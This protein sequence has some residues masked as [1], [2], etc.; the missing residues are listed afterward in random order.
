MLTLFRKPPTEAAAAP[1]E[2]PRRAMSAR[3]YEDMIGNLSGHASAV[4]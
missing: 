3:S 1:A 2:P 4:S